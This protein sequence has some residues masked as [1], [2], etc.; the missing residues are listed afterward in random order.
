MLSLLTDK[1]S[2]IKNLCLD[3]VI[4][5]TEFAF[6]GQGDLVYASRA[7][8]IAAARM[9]HEELN[10]ATEHPFELFI[11]KRPLNKHELERGVYDIVH[12]NVDNYPGSIMIHNGQLA[13]NGRRLTMTHK[14]Y[15]FSRVFGADCSQLEFCNVTVEPL[16]QNALRGLS[17]TLLCYG[18]TGTGY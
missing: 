2:T 9:Q 1:E 16:I 5:I 18:Q 10:K 4:L 13:R 15:L 17:S 6:A 8:R 11:R 3:A 7:R 12:T 14:H